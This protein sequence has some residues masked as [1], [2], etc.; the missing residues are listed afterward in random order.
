M[1]EFR[2]EGRVLR[3]AAR[4]ACGITL[5]V[6]VLAS[7]PRAQT[8]APAA[9]TAAR[10]KLLVLLVVDQMRGDYVEKFQHQWSRGLRRLVTDGAWFRQSGYPYFNVVTC[11]GHASIGTG[12]VPAI[13]GMILNGWWERDTKK[14]VACTD[15]DRSTTISYGKPIVSEGESAVR[16]RTTTLADEL[17]AQLPGA[18]RRRGVL[19]EGAI[20]GHA[21]RSASGR[22][23]V[24]RR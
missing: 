21:V 6:S 9:A 1:A 22:G 14:L 13:H 24:V 18:P 5:G 17:R 15:D 16:L 4:V 11:A 23:R 7:L 12:A 20:R 10:P 3:T 2:R 8:P 19:A